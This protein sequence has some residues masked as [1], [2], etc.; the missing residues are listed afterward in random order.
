MTPD[1]LCALPPRTVVVLNG[2]LFTRFESD[3][4]SGIPE[5][6]CKE[7]RLY[8]AEDLDGAEVYQAPNDGGEGV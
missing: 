4:T 2:A 8:D 6:I 7:G 3:P 5:F 1:D